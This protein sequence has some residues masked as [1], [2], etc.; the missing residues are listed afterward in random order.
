MRHSIAHTVRQGFNDLVNLF[1]PHVCLTCNN[2]LLPEEDLIC[3]HCLSGMPFTGFS[4]DQNNPVYDKLSAI[5]PVQKAGA[6]LLFNKSGLAQELIHHLKYKNRQELGKLVAQWVSRLYDKKLIKGTIDYIVPVPL[7]PRKKKK[8]G[9]NQLTLFGQSL[10][11]YFEVSYREDI[12][13]RSVNTPSQ[14]RKNLKQ[15]RENVAAAFSINHPL[16]YAGKHFLIIDDVM[17][18]GATVEACAETLLKNIPGAR[19]SVLTM[20]VVL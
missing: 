10:A 18:T 19:I 15:R 20:A 5:I 11:E 8:R 17:T 7:H 1:F 4:L 14:T 9:Y 16:R 6:I 12:L 2:L 13:I 3:H